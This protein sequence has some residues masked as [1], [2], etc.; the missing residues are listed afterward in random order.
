MRA[1]AVIFA[2][3]AIG[4]LIFQS[5]TFALPR[6]FAERLADTGL[7]ATLVGWYAFVVFAVAAVGQV[8]V[9]FLVDRLPARAVFGVTAGAQAVLLWAMAGE[10][11][12]TAVLL[13]GAFML[14]VFGQIP[15]N[16]VLVGRITRPAWRSRILAL[17]YLV[18]FTVMASSVP[19]IA[20]MHA[21]WGFDALFRVLSGA[22]AVILACVLALPRL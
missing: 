15:I 5:T 11:G 8:V 16:D 21:E 14:V 6:V 13:A 22:A 18:T 4:G 3:T 17:R 12:F 1:F 9:G 19:F 10:T 20:W 7:S 2:T